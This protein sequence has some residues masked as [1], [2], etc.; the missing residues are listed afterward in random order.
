MAVAAH[1]LDHS[2]DLLGDAQGYAQALIDLGED[3][4]R[5][6]ARLL[7][8]STPVIR[9]D[10]L[11]YAEVDDREKAIGELEDC[12]LYT[13]PSPRDKRQSRMPSSA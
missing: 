11:N 4:S 12:L 1:V 2:A 7:M 3:A 13:S 6:V 10:S 9:E 5:L 8:R